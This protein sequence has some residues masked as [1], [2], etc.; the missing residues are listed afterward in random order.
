MKSECHSNATKCYKTAET[1][2]NC[3]SPY[4][5]FCSFV[6]LNHCYCCCITAITDIHWSIWA[7]SVYTDTGLTLP[8]SAPS[9]FNYWKSIVAP[10]RDRDGGTGGDGTIMQTMTQGGHCVIVFNR[11]PSDSFTVEVQ[12]LAPVTGIFLAFRQWSCKIINRFVEN[13]WEKVQ[14]VWG[15]TNV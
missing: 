14:V 12:H 4:P 8:A 15:K 3:K 13:N 2:S 11:P 10:T 6:Q 7:S 9:S 1:N 5:S